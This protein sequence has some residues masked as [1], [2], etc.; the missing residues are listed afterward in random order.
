MPINDVQPRAIEANAKFKRDRADG[1]PTSM[2]LGLAAKYPSAG[3]KWPWAYVFPAGRRAT[4]P[5]DG[6]VKRHHLTE[7]VVQVA[8]PPAAERAGVAKHVRP[9]V[10]RHA[11]ATHLL[12]DEYDIR[13]V[14]ELPGHASVETTMIY[15]QVL[16]RGGRG[17][18]SPSD[19]LG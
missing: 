17:V 12:E 18:R 5:R 14:Q 7:R 2:T 9:H 6:T 16:N 19:G 3:L 4:D 11:F 1:V 10:L 8:L 15:T 13:T